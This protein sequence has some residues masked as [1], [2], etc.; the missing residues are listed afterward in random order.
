MAGNYIYYRYINFTLEKSLL[1]GVATGSIHAKS[2]KNNKFKTIEIKKI[3]NK[4]KI[5]KE[6]L[7]V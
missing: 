3:S 1:L 5:K 6:N 4:I 2:K 7:N